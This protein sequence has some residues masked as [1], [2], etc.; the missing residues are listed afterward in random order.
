MFDIRPRPFDSND[1]EGE[2]GGDVTDDDG[3]EDE[4]KKDEVEEERGE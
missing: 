1:D 3:D 2:A 4:L